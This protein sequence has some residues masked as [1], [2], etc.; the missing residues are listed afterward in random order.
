MVKI[1]EERRVTS[2]PSPLSIPHQH[3]GINAHLLSAESGYRRAGIH[4]Y[5]DQILRHLPPGNRTYSIY[6]R[7]TGLWNGRGD[8]RPV[9]TRLPTENRL[10]RI[11]WEQVVWPVLA[12]RDGLTLMHSMA[13]AMP[14]LAPCP[15]VVTIYDVSF[16]ESP[17]AFPAAQ[18]RYLMNETAYSCAHAARLIAISESGRRDIHRLYGVPLDRIDVVTP[19]VADVYRPLPEAEV[20]AFRRRRGLPNTFLLH[21]GTLQPRKNLSTLLDALARLQRPDVYLALVGGKGWIYDA[22][23]ERVSALGLGGRVLFAGYVDDD[24]LPLWYNAAAALVMPSLYEGF[25][26]PVVEALACGAPVAAADTS[27]LPETGGDVA[28]Y[29]DPH[30]PD[31]LAARLAQVLDDPAFRNRARRDGP[32]HAARFSW[33]RAGREMA[34]VYERTLLRPEPD[35]A[36]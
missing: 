12:R 13:F 35:E 15:V 29:F 4:R 32:A 14:R 8:F 20:T 7:Q 21:V 6:T 18:R 2:P 10:A 23:F 22:I 9:G 17:E 16:I 11:A 19:G 25:G 34:A 5:I 28:L 27:S 26:L 31:E 33:E 24:E 36:R 30:D 1:F 3:V